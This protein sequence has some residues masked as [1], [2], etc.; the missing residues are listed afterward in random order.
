MQGAGA[1]LGS[2]GGVAV[3]SVPHQIGRGINALKGNPV[4]GARVLKPGFRMAGG[5]LGAILGGQLGVATRDA[6]L[7]DSP[8]AQLIARRQAG[9][10]Q[11]GDD[12]AL[13]NMLAD[14]YS[15]MGIS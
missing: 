12:V 6:M 10:A 5:L 2:L 14:Q 7:R 8:E 1:V 15:R 13:A 3:G 4:K 11:P 9:L